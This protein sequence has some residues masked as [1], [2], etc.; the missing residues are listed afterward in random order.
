[1]AVALV[2]ALMS[3]GSGSPTT[4]KAASKTGAKVVVVKHANPH[5]TPAPA[6]APPAVP[7]NAAEISV[8]VLN[9]TETTGLAHR[10]ARQ[11]QQVGYTQSVALD[12]RPPGANQQSAVEYAPGH[13][14]DAESVARSL[15]IAHVQAL[16]SAV[17]SLAGSASVVVVMGADKAASSP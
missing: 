15:T 10:T 3:G 2:V 12:G 1:V 6:P 17:A 7:A 5:P 4:T 14:S 11:L 8:V 13:Q 16:E 9:G